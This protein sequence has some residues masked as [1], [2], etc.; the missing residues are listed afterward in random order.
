MNKLCIFVMSAVAIALSVGMINAFYSLSSRQVITENFEQL[1]G[2]EDFGEW[3][4]NSHVPFDPNR[5]G[6]TV[7]WHIRRASNVSRSGMYSAE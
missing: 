6:N 5:P 2:D 1:L 7:E 3:V 4:A